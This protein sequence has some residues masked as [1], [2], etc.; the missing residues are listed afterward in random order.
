MFDLVTGFAIVGA[1]LVLSAL[2]SPLVQRGPISFPIIF[3][4]LGFA[5][6]P[7]GL[8]IRAI[9]PHDRVLETIGTLTLALV[10]FL[11]AGKIQVD[12]LGRHWPVPVL[13]LGPG[14][15]LIVVLIAGASWLILGLAVVPALIVGVALALIAILLI[16]P[17]VLMAVLGRVKM[18]SVARGFIA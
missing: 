15:L 1:V 9:E 2:A 18:S 7:H 8:Q 12:E 4:G 16:R 17:A 6:G 13:I 10:L 11:D 3:L 5:F 14:T